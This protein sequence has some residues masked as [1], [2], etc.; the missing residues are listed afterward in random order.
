MS[1]VVIQTLKKHFGKINAIDGISIDVP[2]GQI[3][4]FL[5]PN[6][7]GK[8]TTIR[9]MMNFIHPSEGTITLLGK[10]SK[11]D[12]VEL[13]KDVG[14]LSSDI[15]LYDNWTGQEHIDFVE[16]IRDNGNYAKDLV[17]RL[18]FDG[19][20]KVKH[21]STGNKQKLGIILAFAGNPRLLILDEPTR[22]LDPLLQNEM[23][24][25]LRELQENGT[26]VFMSSHNLPEVEKV[27][28]QVAIIKNGLLIETGN[29]EA[30][31]KRN[32]HIITAYFT[33]DYSKD[34]FTD[35][36]I[37]GIIELPQGLQF[38]A[39]GDINPL[40]AKLSNHTLKDLEV[41]HA[42]L[43]DIFMEVYNQ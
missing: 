31:Q 36:G 7:A 29:I 22:G 4:G 32:V 35:S 10:D 25:I 9:C 20:R 24:T 26:T 17:A 33:D 18:G 8:T 23:Y 34:E 19:K 30:I 12:Y 3:F 14:Y 39:R 27:C 43:E 38:T 5:G 6:G 1:A 15:S 37:E 11:K 2:E 40:I 28:D 41:A 16:K 21:L 42:S 13:K